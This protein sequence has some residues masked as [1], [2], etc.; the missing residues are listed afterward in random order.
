MSLLVNLSNEKENA[1]FSILVIEDSKTDFIYLQHLLKEVGYEIYRAETIKQAIETLKNQEFNLIF[2][3]MNLPDSMQLEGLRALTG[4]VGDTP[5]VI[6]TGIEKNCELELEAMKEGAACT[7]YKEDIS[8][9]RLRDL[10][11]YAIDR[12]KVLIKFRDSLRNQVTEEALFSDISNLKA[13][14]KLAKELGVT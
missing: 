1:P 2:L 3:D 11:R 8:P 10:V 5:I 12:F 7:F 13:L 9:D 6:M 4:L 14:R